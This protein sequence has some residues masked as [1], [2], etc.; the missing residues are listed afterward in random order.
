[1]HYFAKKKL[2]LYYRKSQFHPKKKAFFKKV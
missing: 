2:E 1:M